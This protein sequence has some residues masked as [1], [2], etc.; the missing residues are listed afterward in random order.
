MKIMRFNNLSITR[1]INLILAVTAT[2]IITGLIILLLQG[3]EAMYVEK[4]KNA[5]LLVRHALSVIETHHQFA[6]A[7]LMSDEEAKK[8]ASEIISHMR[9]GE[10][11]YFWIQT[12]EPRMVMHPAKPEL[13]GSQMKDMLAPDGRSLLEVFAELARNEA[14]GNLRYDWPK[15]GMEKLQP[16]IL[17]V[18][19]YA[20]WDWIVGTGIYA[21]DIEAAFISKAL[22]QGGG[23]IAFMLLAGFL[24]HRV[25]RKHVAA[26]IEAKEADERCHSNKA[27]HRI[28]APE[29]RQ[30]PQFNQVL[31]AQLN[32][33][34]EETEKAAFDVTS[35]LQTIDEVVID[36]NGFVSQ[37]S[38]E[39]ASTSRDSE[40]QMA[41]NHLLIQKLESFIQQRIE[42]AKEDKRRSDEAVRQAKS[43]TTL[44]DFIKDISAQTNLLAL[45]AAIEAAR[46]GEAGRGF[47]VVAD[48]VRKLSSETETAVKKINDG[49]NSVSSIIENQFK[50]KMAD[51]MVANERASLEEF[52]AQ[53]AKLGSSYD[54]LT[55]RER[56][57]LEHINSSSDKLSAMFM[58]CLASV[59]FQD[60]T[61]QQI[62]HV[63]EGLSRID[64]H[65]TELADVFERK[66]AELAEETTAAVQPL[67]GQLEGLFSGYVM[68]QQRTT[69]QDVLARIMSGKPAENGPG[70][71]PPTAPAERKPAAAE[72]PKIE[73][74]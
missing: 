70:R 26:P 12:S 64:V 10:N 52:A 55:Q 28:V 44:I 7:G 68:P 54:S 48:E 1:K 6:R 8:R 14:G 40:K 49:I 22:K 3:R 74:F 50:D 65:A 34:V 38:A 47:A 4:T 20:P 60:I 71:K 59:Q 66:E 19:R 9:Q 73:L 62:S 29:L 61:R 24:F 46:A 43:L 67:A 72:P 39:S 51:S 18:E 33:V 35:R 31:A 45:N 25:I 53:L 5:E 23:V 15:P 21:D 32:H 57:L 36:L 63:I 37:A 41:E 16:K 27:C 2:G 56:A 58:D 69:H 30:V 17:H 42:D 11:D 13:N